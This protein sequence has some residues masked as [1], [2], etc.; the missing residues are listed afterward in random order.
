MAWSFRRRVKLIPGVHLNFSKNGIS[1]TIGVRGASMTFGKRGTYVNTGISGTGF[2][3]RQK[4][5]SGRSNPN[6]NSIPEPTEV[7]DPADNIISV[8]AEEVTSQNMAGIKEAII[9]AHKQRHELS[10]DIIKVNNVSC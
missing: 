9:N 1:T 2:Y 10:K 3:N 8:D 6:N 7:I 5:S 4:V